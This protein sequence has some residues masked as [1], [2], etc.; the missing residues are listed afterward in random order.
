MDGRDHVPALADIE[1]LELRKALDE[2][3]SKMNGYFS[4]E[5]VQRDVLLSYL[6][7]IFSA[8]RGIKIPPLHAAAI[9]FVRTDGHTGCHASV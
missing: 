6:M 7:R 2:L 8:S 3:A 1:V 4:K 9:G 5:D